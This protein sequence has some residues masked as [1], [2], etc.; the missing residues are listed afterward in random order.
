M[1]EAS[2]ASADAQDRTGMPP[3][4]VGDPALV[5]WSRYRGRVVLFTSTVNMD[6]TTW[7]VSPSFPALM[8]E[9]LHFAVAG[10]LREHAATVGDLLE[11]YLPPG[12]AG[13]DFTLQTP[14]GRVETGRTLLQPEGGLLRWTDTDISGIHRMTL[15]QHPREYLFAVNVPTAAESQQA[16]ESDPARTNQTELQST[17]PGWEFQLVTDLRQVVHSGGPVPDFSGE[18]P[19]R[20]IGAVVARWL[21][22]TAVVLLVVEIVLAWRFGHYSEVP[23]VWHGGPAPGRILPL[24]VAGTA[25][26]LFLLLAGVLVHAACTGDFLGFLPEAARAAI[27]ARLSIPPPAAGEGTR[28]HLEF[29]PYLWDATADP[30]LAGTLALGLAVLVVAIYLREGHTAGTAYKGLLAGLRVFF[31]LLMLAVLLPQLRLWFEREGWPDVAILIDDSRSMSTTDHYRDRATEEAVRR[32]AEENGLS[33]PERLQLAQAVLTRARGEWLEALLTKRRVKLHI[34]HC[35]TR[36][37]RIADIGQR[38]EL[39]TAVRRIGELRPEGESTQLGGAVRQVLNDFRGSSLA[40]ILALTDGITTEGEDLDHASRYAAQLGVPLFFLGIGDDHEVRDLKLHDLQVEDSVY[41]NDRLIFEG[42]LTSQGYADEHAVTITLYEKDPGGR[43]KALASTVVKTDPAGKPLKFRLMHQP[44]EPGEKTYVIEA[45]ASVEATKTANKNRLERHVFVREAKLI[46]VLY[47]EGYARYD[48]RF[49]KNLLERESVR[50]K[51]NK[52]MDLKV[53]LLDADNEYAS[54]DRSAL[55]DFPTREELNGYDVVLFG[56][57]DPK[58]RKIGERNLRHLANF[59]KERGGGLLM[60]AGPRYSPHAYKNSPLRDILPVQV[61]GA[62]PAENERIAGFR[63]ELT[64]IGRS[65]PIFRFSPDETANRTIWNHLAE[66]HWYASGIRI[67]R[68]AEVLLVHPQR[69]ATDSARAGA[70]EPGGYP[71]F[72]QQFVGAGRSMFLGFDETWRW[73]FRE[74]E[75]RFNQFWIQTVRYLARSRLGRVELR[76]DRQTPYRRGEP[77][78][79]TVRFPDDAPPPGADTK[80]DVIATRTPLRRAGAVGSQMS[81]PAPA[82]IEKETLRLAKLE[83]SRATY[84]AV[85]TRTPEGEYRFRL[86]APVVGD[87]KPQVD[88]RVLPPPGELDQLQMNRLGMSRAADETH[89][90]FYGV[91]DAQRLVD[92]LPSG[93]RVAL[94]APQP[95]RLLWNHFA[96]FALTL[97]LLGTEWTLRKRKHLL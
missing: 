45:P 62:A 23:G 54:E 10:S 91:A 19:L 66:L 49:I 24:L 7:P 84:E 13:L 8:Q 64:S 43:L 12:G 28:W 59:V 86:S 70:A 76:V 40:A 88:S 61:A 29:T 18:R 63:P 75:L 1:P 94:S 67:P 38:R 85:L 9:L 31:L 25:A 72:A 87:P 58:D 32:L 35:S 93:T 97:G 83:G 74:D 69:P 5:E 82:E 80:V 30:W 42:R 16:C 41:V 11:E 50:D 68:A 17:Y 53:L 15:G 46:K 51:R 6:W 57:V 26:A 71:L 78:K 73:R 79:V 20:G 48:Y 33:S 65:H 37:A 55:A 2:T 47:V 90:R 22:L 4:P 95:P 27:E 21:L 89:G 77:I 36:A 14:D 39:D 34:Y 3:L 56:D 60:I 44:T 96:M 81:E 92:D 52:T